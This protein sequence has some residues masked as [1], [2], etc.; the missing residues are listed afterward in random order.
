VKVLSKK[1]IFIA[2]SKLDLLHKHSR[3]AH[4]KYR[5]IALLQF[6]GQGWFSHIF[7]KKN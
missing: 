7:A 6:L 4:T 3:K 5:L 2:A 1:S